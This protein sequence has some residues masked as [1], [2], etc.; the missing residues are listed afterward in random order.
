MRSDGLGSFFCILRVGL[1]AQGVDELEQLGLRN[2]Y[3]GLLNLDVLLLAVELLNQCIASGASIGIRGGIALGTRAN[4]EVATHDYAA[5]LVTLMTLSPLIDEFVM[6]IC[7]TSVTL[8][9]R[10]SAST[11][12]LWSMRVSA[13]TL[14]IV[15]MMSFK[16][17]AV[18]WSTLLPT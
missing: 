10:R 7:L 14:K 11:I 9:T 16:L 3:V 17:S 12:V 5:P 1:G 8:P 18:F 15:E 13:P 2:R 4:D 6:V